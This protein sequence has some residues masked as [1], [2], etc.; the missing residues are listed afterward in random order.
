MCRE[1]KLGKLRKKPYDCPRHKLSIFTKFVPT[2]LLAREKQRYSLFHRALEINSK[3]SR[4]LLRIYESIPEKS[5]FLFVRCC[6]EHLFNNTCSRM[7]AELDRLSASQCRVLF[8]IMLRNLD[9]Q[10]VVGR[11]HQSYVRFA[12]ILLERHEADSGRLRRRGP[13]LDDNSVSL[14]KKILK[15]KSHKSAVCRTIVVTVAEKYWNEHRKVWLQFLSIIAENNTPATI[16]STIRK[17]D[18]SNPNAAV[19]LLNAYRAAD[20]KR[21][22]HKKLL[23][24]SADCNFI[25]FVSTSVVLRKLALACAENLLYQRPVAIN[26]GVWI[27]GSDSKR[28]NADAHAKRV[29]A[30]FDAKADRVLRLVEPDSRYSFYELGKV[31]ENE[32]VLSKNSMIARGFLDK[33]SRA[34]KNH[35]FFNIDSRNDVSR[36]LRALRLYLFPQ[37]RRDN[38][39]KTLFESSLQVL[40]ESTNYSRT[41]SERDAHGSYFLKYVDFGRRMNG[42]KFTMSFDKNMA[43]ILPVYSIYDPYRVERVER[44]INYMARSGNLDVVCRYFLNQF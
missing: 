12:D 7:V 13:I 41:A 42:Q 20:S 19:D 3:Y 4:P 34:M 1:H 16:L 6:L 33:L 8:G 31:V 9:K 35:L 29:L 30:T 36:Y 17:I 24:Y 15:K 5:K 2:L 37:L 10:N 23:F 44:E 27:S 43:K 21:D 11:Y 14:I 26:V 18:K 25:T 39:P 32:C 22:V 38:V 40:I 28:I